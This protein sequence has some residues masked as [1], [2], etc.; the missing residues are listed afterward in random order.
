MAF[1][2]RKQGIQKARV[3]EDMEEVRK[4]IH[5]LP[6]LKSNFKELEKQLKPSQTL[7]NHMKLELR[8]TQQLEL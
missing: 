7:F 6:N 1:S 4:Q 8:V 2:D 3:K 5:S